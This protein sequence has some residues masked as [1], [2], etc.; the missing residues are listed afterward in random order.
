MAWAYDLVSWVVSLGN[1]DALRKSVL[2][3]Q[4]GTRVLEIGFGT[5]ELLLEMRRQGIW[6]IGLDRSPA[7]QRQTRNKMRRLGLW[8]P[9]VQ[10][11]S[12]RTPFASH[13]FDT[14]YATFPAGYIFEADTWREV[15]RLLNKPGRFVV[16]GIGT[17]N[18]TRQPS[19]L[20]R[21]IF[22][23]PMEPLERR[24]QDLASAA[25]LSLRLVPH[26]QGRF[27]IPILIA[28]V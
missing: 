17:S 24:F 13:C 23:P 15:G 3:Y 14:I 22:G 1:W 16:V 25:G 2:A 26:H 12:L 8:A 7:M 27:A 28:E 18:A 19:R 11:S 21:L 10:A 9:R 5:G 4:L 6:A 20:S